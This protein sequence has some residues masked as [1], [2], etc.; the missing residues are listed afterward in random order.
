[1][2]SLQFWAI[3]SIN[4]NIVECKDNVTGSWDDSAHSINRNI[5]ECKVKN[6]PIVPENG[7]RINRNIV[8]CKDNGTWKGLYYLNNVLIETLWNVKR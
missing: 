5:V 1:M 8:E 2:S 6:F 3:R 4:R 7:N